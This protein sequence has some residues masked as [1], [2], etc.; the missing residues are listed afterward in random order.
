MVDHCVLDGKA[1]VG[2]QDRLVIG[3][4]VLARVGDLALLHGGAGRVEVPVFGLRAGQRHGPQPANANN[5]VHCGRRHKVDILNGLLQNGDVCVQIGG[6]SGA[7]RHDEIAAAVNRDEVIAARAHIHRELLRI[8]QRIAVFYRQCVGLRGGL[9]CSRA[10]C[11][12]Q[13]GQ[14]EECRAPHSAAA[15]VALSKVRV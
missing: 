6:R 7:L 3:G 2:G 13:G 4:T 10:P 15:S 8:F 12:Q 11:Q 1:A 14:S 5:G 9:G